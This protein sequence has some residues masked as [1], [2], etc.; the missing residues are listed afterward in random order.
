MV[1]HY[2]DDDIPGPAADIEIRFAGLD[3]TDGTA[4]IREFRIDENHSNAF[5]Q[6]NRFGSPQQ[7]TAEQY[8]QLEKAGRLAELP[9]RQSPVQKGETVLKLILPRQ[10]VSLVQLSW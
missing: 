8:D 5:A 4:T 9:A 7:P 1:W 6:W 10:A 3:L 2:H